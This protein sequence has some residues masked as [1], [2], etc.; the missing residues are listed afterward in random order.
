MVFEKMFFEQYLFEKY[1]FEKQFSK[2]NYSKNIFQKKNRKIC[3]AQYFFQNIFIEKFVL[4]NVLK[5]LFSRQLPMK[6]NETFRTFSN[7]LGHFP[8]SSPHEFP[9]ENFQKRPKQFFI[10]Y[11]LFFSFSVN[12]FP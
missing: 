9:I 10:L 5:G 8:S 7:T 12:N 1:V 4:K 2:N 6:S 11:F 3:I